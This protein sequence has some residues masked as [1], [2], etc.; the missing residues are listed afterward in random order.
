MIKSGCTPGQELN[1][2]WEEKRALNALPTCGRRAYSPVDM[3]TFRREEQYH[4]TY[5]E[6][7]IYGLDEFLMSKEIDPAQFDSVN[8][9]I[10]FVEEAP[11]DYSPHNKRC[12]TPSP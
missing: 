2:A 3:S 1:A 10:R 11:A 5:D 6:G 12:P 4:D 9:K 8:H 7:T